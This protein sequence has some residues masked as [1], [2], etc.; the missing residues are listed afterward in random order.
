MSYNKVKVLGEKCMFDFLESREKR[1]AFKKA[2]KEVVREKPE[3]ITFRKSNSEASDGPKVTRVNPYL[4]SSRNPLRKP[5]TTAIDLKY[6]KDWR[7]VE[8]V[9]SNNPVYQPKPQSKKP[10]FDDDGGVQPAIALPGTQKQESKVTT[11]EIIEKFAIK[12]KEEKTDKNANKY[13]MQTIKPKP[14]QH[15]IPR[16]KQEPTT[17]SAINQTKN[18]QSENENKIKVEVIDF[19]PKQEPKPVKPKTNRKP[20]GKGKRRFDA[21]VI[22]SVDWK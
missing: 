20:R 12:P 19:T 2:L 9:P 14:E 21:D 4:S 3:P 8:K 16:P 6:F 1:R 15:C 10:L 18:T 13:I 22:T 11:N 5:E 7:K 17:N